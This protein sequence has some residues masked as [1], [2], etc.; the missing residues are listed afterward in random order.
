MRGPETDA[1][2]GLSV[3]CDGLGPWPAAVI[4]HCHLAAAGETVILLHPLYFYEIFQK[5]SKGVSSQ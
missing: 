1:A 4:D 2:E 5:G 3:D